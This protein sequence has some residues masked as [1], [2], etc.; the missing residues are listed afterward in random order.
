MAA[1]WTFIF[2]LVLGMAGAT[3]FFGSV[4]QEKENAY[5]EQGYSDGYKAGREEKTT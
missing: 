4:K 5:Y 3:F 1:V 2:G